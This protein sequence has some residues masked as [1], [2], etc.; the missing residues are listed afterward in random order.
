LQS[1]DQFILKNKAKIVAAIQ[2]ASAAAS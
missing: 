1:F 2:S